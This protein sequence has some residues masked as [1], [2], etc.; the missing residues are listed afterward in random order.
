MWSRRATTR[1][2]AERLIRSTRL[3]YCIKFNCS[4]TGIATALRI[5][6]VLLVE[7]SEP[8]ALNSRSQHRNL[9]E[10]P[11]SELPHLH[12]RLCIQT[13]EITPDCTELQD[14]MEF[15]WQTGP[16]EASSPD[17]NNSRSGTSS[18]THS[19]ELSQSGLFRLSVRCF[20]LQGH[21]PGR[22]LSGTPVSPG[23]ASSEPHRRAYPWYTCQGDPWR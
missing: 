14:R 3:P 20:Y 16:L 12:E 17:S 1:S 2:G 22:Q 11:F 8:A 4:P 18:V 10:N 21:S 13:D 9:E 15:P 23:E 5:H 7:T 19:S 6:G